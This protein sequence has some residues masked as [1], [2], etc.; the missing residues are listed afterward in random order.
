MTRRTTL[1]LDEVNDLKPHGETPEENAEYF[2]ENL[3]TVDE[4]ELDRLLK[5]FGTR[6]EGP[7]S[8]AVPIGQESAHKR[9][10][11]LLRLVD[12]CAFLR[13]CRDDAATLTEPEWYQMACLLASQFG[14][15]G[16]GA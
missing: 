10:E 4:A 2:L 14:G 6:A 3:I 13:H 7:R 1:L 9:N 11:G 5:V 8:E 15:P 12:A 16:S